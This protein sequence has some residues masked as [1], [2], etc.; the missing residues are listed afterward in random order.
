M[1]S[2]FANKDCKFLVEEELGRKKFSCLFLTLQE[3]YESLL[4]AIFPIET[5][6]QILKEWRRMLG[7]VAKI[8]S[9]GLTLHQSRKQNKQTNKQANKQKNSCGLAKKGVEISG[10]ILIGQSQNHTKDKR[11]LI[12][13]YD[14]KQKL[15]SSR[16][17]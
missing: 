2:R 13:T 14:K 5:F 7:V 9:S 17:K 8:N 1:K 15:L 10:Y 6:F 12:V 11:R 4:G 3:F 16:H